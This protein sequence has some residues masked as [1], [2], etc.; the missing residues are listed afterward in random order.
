MTFRVLENVAELA[1]TPLLLVHAIVRVFAAGLWSVLL[2][3][4]HDGVAYAQIDIDTTACTHLLVR[5]WTMTCGDGK[6]VGLHLHLIGLDSLV[7]KT[8]II[9]P[10]KINRSARRC[11]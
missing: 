10:K 11:I 8:P 5:S 3:R 4:K 9:T 6:E 2:G 1:L 7:H